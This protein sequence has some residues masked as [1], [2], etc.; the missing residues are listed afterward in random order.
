[1]QL[2]SVIPLHDGLGSV[3]VIAL[4][5]F[6]LVFLICTLCVFVE[7]AMTVGLALAGTIEIL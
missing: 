2:P 7:P 3:T 4:E 6:E 5:E 1:M